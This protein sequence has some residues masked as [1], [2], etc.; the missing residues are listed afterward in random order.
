MTPFI[1]VIVKVGE[2]SSENFVSANISR[3]YEVLVSRSKCLA[4]AFNERKSV[5]PCCW[6][7]P[8]SAEDKIE[9]PQ[10]S[11]IT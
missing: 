4:S 9:G 8:F 2:F 6:S 1:E 10:I 11:E 5:L 7:S 3:T